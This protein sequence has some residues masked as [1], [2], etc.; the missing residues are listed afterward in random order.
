MRY[1]EVSGCSKHFTNNNIRMKVLED[2][3]LSIDKGEF[4]CLLGSSGCGKTTLLRMMAGIE[5]VTSGSIQCNGEKISKPQMKYAYIFQ[6]FNQYFPW[7]TIRKNIEYPFTINKR[8]NRKAIGEK[9]DELLNLIELNGSAN[10]YPHT[11][12]GG[13]KQRVAIAR[14][15]AMQPKVLFMDEP[16]SAL[17]TKMREKLQSELLK[18]WKEFELTIVFVTHSIAEAILLATKI[19]V[20]N[21]N[22]K[23]GNPGRIV[24]IIDSEENHPKTPADAG[25]FEL[26]NL[27]REIA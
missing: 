13:M 5:S 23:N 25:Y 15:L 19:V 14:A 27:L 1:F 10:C 24:K 7:K 18:I 8:G 9:V 2:I 6:D 22:P 26:W 21:G 12:S 4:V 20:L 16:F 3:N 17:D 11:L